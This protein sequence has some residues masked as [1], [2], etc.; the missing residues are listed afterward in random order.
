MVMFLPLPSSTTSGRTKIFCLLVILNWQEMVVCPLTFPKNS[1]G[2]H[3]WPIVS[4]D[5]KRY[6]H[7]WHSKKN[8]S[9]CIKYVSLIHL[10][11]EE[12]ELL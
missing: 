9:I 10:E 2:P 11:E 12:Y 8:Y 1:I 4:V 5:E 7:C 3:L 6:N